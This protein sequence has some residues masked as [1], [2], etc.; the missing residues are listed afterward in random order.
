MKL[1][2]EYEKIFIHLEYILLLGPLR[3]KGPENLNRKLTPTIIN[4]SLFNT[5]NI[6]WY[7]NIF[8]NHDENNTMIPILFE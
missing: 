8:N 7:E 4:G 3:N 5:T 6:L 2:L 1:L